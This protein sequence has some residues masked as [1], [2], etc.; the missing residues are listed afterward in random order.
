MHRK[1]ALITLAIVMVFAMVTAASAQVKTGPSAMAN[2]TQK[3][4]LL[5]W[6]K[7]VVEGAHGESF[8]GPWRDT[9][10]FLSNDRPADT[11]IQCYW[12]DEFQ[13]IEDFNFKL[14]PNQPIFFSAAHG[15]NIPFP[16]FINDPPVTVPPFA[17]NNDADSAIGALYCWAVNSDDSSAIPVNH[18]YGNAL[19]L[20]GD[21]SFDEEGGLEVEI[22]GTV[23]YNA[24]SF[25]MYRT[26]AAPTGT[27]QVL[28][29]DGLTYDACPSYLLANFS[30]LT[31]IFDVS[32]SLT[33]VPCKQDLTQDRTPTYTKAKFDIWNANETKYTGA[34]QC[35]KCFAEFWLDDLGENSGRTY[36]TTGHDLGVGFG[37]DK[38][39][40][41]A[42][43]TIADR[44]RVYGVQSTVC[45]TPTTNTGLLG[46]LLYEDEA[47]S[48]IYAGTTLHGAGLANK[49]GATG[50]V[51]SITWDIG[52]GSQEAGGK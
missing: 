45:R 22:Q 27:T 51:G 15:Q 1:I 11:W 6:P 20:S 18:L 43:K 4:S 13:Q 25:A 9:I 33:L 52:S 8:L 40:I 12:M 19:L 50:D 44:F 46:L 37:G 47:S 3:G 31:G 23:F 48:A 21:T 38:F 49:T 29:L 26:L 32:P 42:L 5:V 28:P 17:L 16:P 7:I 39:E 36:S 24:Y 14:T 34:Y 41:T 10:I 35:F 2:T 30:P